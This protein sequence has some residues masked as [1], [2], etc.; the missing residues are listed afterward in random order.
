LY[1]IKY[2]ISVKNFEGFGYSYLLC[3]VDVVIKFSKLVIVQYPPTYYSCTEFS[4]CF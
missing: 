1:V 2:C 4:A 3:T